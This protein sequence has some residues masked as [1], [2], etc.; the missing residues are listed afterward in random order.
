MAEGGNKERGRAARAKG[1]MNR[2][3]AERKHRVVILVTAEQH[4]SGGAGNSYR[5]LNI[6]SYS[7]ERKGNHRGQAHQTVGSFSSKN[8]EFPA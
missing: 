7:R 1:G 3:P 2:I 4:R 6:E 5:S 8:H